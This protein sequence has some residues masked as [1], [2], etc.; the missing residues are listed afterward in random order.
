[1]RTIL[2]V[3]GGGSTLTLDRAL[4][5]RHLGEEIPITGGRSLQARAEVGLLSHNILIRG[6]DNPQWHDKIEACA[7]GFDT[8]KPM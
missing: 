8:G 5:Y 1:M 2:S 4:D 7:A 3:S 6:N